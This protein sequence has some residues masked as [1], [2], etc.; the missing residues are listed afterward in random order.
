MG[1]EEKKTGVNDPKADVALKQKLA[2][3]FADL[4]IEVEGSITQISDGAH[5]EF[6]H[7][8]INPETLCELLKRPVVTVEDV[9]S[10]IESKKLTSDIIVTDTSP[11]KLGAV[12]LVRHA[13]NHGPEI[14]ACILAASGP[15]GKWREK[16]PKILHELGRRGDITLAHVKLLVE[17]GWSVDDVNNDGWTPL[18][19]AVWCRNVSLC[20]ALVALGANRHAAIPEDGHFPGTTAT[21]MFVRG[22]FEENAR[23][24]LDALQKT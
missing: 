8:E 14:L 1:L 7:G 17:Y 12:T 2:K 22:P 4:G 24:P 15:K 6:R 23:H 16:A 19:S 18:H 21:Q 3:A 5:C 20:Q 13:C 9:K 11:G 10:F